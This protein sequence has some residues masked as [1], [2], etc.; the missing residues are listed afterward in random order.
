MV[1]AA[2]RELEAL[3]LATAGD[4]GD[5]NAQR[6]DELSEPVRRYLTASVPAGAPVA[7]AGVLRMRGQI[8]IGRWLPFRARQLLA[9]ALG[10]VWEARVGGLIVGSDRYVCGTG[11]MEWKLLGLFPLVH[12]GGDD[13]SRSA[14]ERA[15]GESIWVPTALLPGTEARWSADDDTHISVTLETDGHS[16]TLHH[17]LDSAGRIRLSRFQRWGDPENTGQWS[18]L[19]F[20]V[21][22]TAYR[23]FDGV[24]IPSAGR[25]GW[26]AGTD[27]WEAGEFFRYR[28]TDYRLLV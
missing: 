11:G 22:V 7:R 6:V 18:E 23:T 24:T 25:V 2:W 10:T 5:V 28:I 21:D 14:A 26:Y 1:T 27:R 13:V 19:P 3:V 12:A 4:V 8:K 9:P 15:A 20:G 17:E 16:V